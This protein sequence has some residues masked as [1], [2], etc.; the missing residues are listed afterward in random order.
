ME[1]IVDEASSLSARLGTEHL[2][3][4][5]EKLGMA[6]FYLLDAE[7]LKEAYFPELQAVALRPG[8]PGY[9]RRYL[10]AHALGHH[11]FH[12]DAQ[13]VDYLRFH[14]LTPGPP[15]EEEQARMAEVESEADLFAAYLLV[16]HEKLAPFLEQQEIWKDAD[17]AQSLAL[18]F[19]VPV[20]AMRIRLV[21]ER[22]L[23][24]RNRE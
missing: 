17:P 22:C 10:L 14:S 18:E 23:R 11:L 12:K 21:Y 7:D 2:D 24:L 19:R 16:P 5:A 13:G 4:V 9:E 3:Q 8:L 15:S 20:E 6:V 1:R